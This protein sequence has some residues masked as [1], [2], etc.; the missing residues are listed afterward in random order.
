MKNKIFT[1]ENYLESY[2]N[3]IEKVN[4]GEIE[5][6]IDLIKD[7]INKKK[8]IYTCGNGG[9]A[10]TASHFIT[11]WKKMYNLATG[12][13]MYSHALT[14]NLG[15]ITAYAND[16]NYDDIFSEQL[17]PVLNEDDL[18]ICISG[19]GNSKNILKAIEYAN[20][21]NA[22]TLGILG[23]DGGQAIKKCKYNVLV[24]CFDMQL[25]EDFH[26]QIGHMVMKSICNTEIKN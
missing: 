20:S 6:A 23:Y 16:V 12:E 24:N 15:L 3:L 5:N 26:L 22:V 11:D 8:S 17:K 2:R 7:M 10:H 9:S 25:V 14:D 21:V 18:V 4:I 19:S 13:K 1:I